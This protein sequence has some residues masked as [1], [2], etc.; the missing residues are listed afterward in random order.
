MSKL[1]F[2][3]KEDTFRSFHD[4]VLVSWSLLFISKNILSREITESLL[5]AILK[6]YFAV[7]NVNVEVIF[8]A[9]TVRNEVSL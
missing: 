9:N 8:K 6:N 2:S 7:G 3:P 4:H 1:S 5:K